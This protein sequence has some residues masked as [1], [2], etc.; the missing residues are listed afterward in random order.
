MKVFK[1]LLQYGF[2]ILGDGLG[3]GDGILAINVFD[4]I[5]IDRWYEL[6]LIFW[7]MVEIY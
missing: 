2:S 4:G 5:C 1:V 6:R 3:I 7:F